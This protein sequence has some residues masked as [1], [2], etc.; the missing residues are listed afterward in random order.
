MANRIKGIT[1]E[2]GG[3]TTK[4]QSALKEVESSLKNTQGQLKDVNKLLKLDPTNTELLRQKHE[5]LGKAVEDSNKR[6]DKLNDA[7][8]QMQASPD[9]DKT[10]EQQNAIKRE[11]IETENSLKS[12]EEQLSK[13]NVALNVIAGTSKD[14][15]EK[16]KAVSAAAAGLAGAM[17]GNAVA[18]ASAADDL[19]ALAQ[20]TGFSVEE[21]Q[22]MQYASDVVDVSMESMTGSITKM[23]KQMSSGNKAFE[24][25]GVSL[26]DANG[27]M[28]DARD[29]W[30]D[31]LD[32]LGKIE[33]ETERDALSMEIFGKSAMDMAGIVDDGGQALKDLGDEAESLGLIMS[34]DMVDDA[35]LM[36]DAIDKMKGRTSQAFLTM[37][38]SLAKTLVP[39]FEKILD[40]VTKVVQWFSSLNG[41]TQKVILVILGL[42]AAISPLAAI[43]SKVTDIVGALS[44][45]FAFF[46][47]PVGLTIAAIAA[48]IAI[49]VALY[50][51]WDKI[52]EKAKSLLDS[53]KGTFDKIKTSISDKINQ[54]KEAVSNAIE[55][56]KGLMNFQWTL[57]K[58]K[59]PHITWTAEPVDPSKWYYKILEVLGLPTSLPKLNVDWYAKA[60]RNGMILNQPT[61]FGAMNGHLLGAGEAGSE[62]V[63]GTN[64]LMNMIRQASGGGMTVNMTVNGGN[65]SANE[66]AD[67]VIDKLTMKIQRNNQRW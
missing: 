2:I 54:A 16:T 59:L 23:T 11:I 62:V 13:S 27:N 28:R 49:G 3:D 60:M 44:S 21:L 25:L 7:L 6:L 66:L 24:K 9:A 37:G 29:V 39:A 15:A 4:L 1:I 64:S 63:V 45:A 46:T 38:A 31:S 30:Y 36:Q 17:L 56:I 12:Y 52:K 22:K 42:V 41:G 47:S 57:P 48:L 43:L 32:A 53:I 50:K 65:L 26:E 61:I 51:N 10:I 35:N 5:L 34:Q 14:V 20:Q 19:N 18:A 58:F 8:K 40:A 33:N 55:K 67:I